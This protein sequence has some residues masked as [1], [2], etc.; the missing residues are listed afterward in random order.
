MTAAHTTNVRIAR[1]RDERAFQIGLLCRPCARRRRA[2]TRSRR[3]SV[4]EVGAPCE[5][6]TTGSPGL[7]FGLSNWPQLTV[8]VEPVHGQNDTC[9]RRRKRPPM[10]P[11]FHAIFGCKAILYTPQVD[12]G[13]IGSTLAFMAQEIPTA[14][15]R[16]NLARVVRR[17]AAGTRIKLTRYGKIQ[18][19]LVPEDD[20][21]FLEDC[22][23]RGTRRG[24]RRA[25]RRLSRR[26]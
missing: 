13:P 5:L 9:G 1:R 17:S 15:A 2:L 12:P 20:L 18:A 22:E 11:K 21:M 26:S 25:K 23:R 16:K 10:R 7:M 24:T 8:F 4:T 14:L 3:G 6:P 19:V